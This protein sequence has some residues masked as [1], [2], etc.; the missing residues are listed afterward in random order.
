LIRA[1]RKLAFLVDQRQHVHRST[2]EQVE[3]TLDMIVV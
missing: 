3:H 2:G 1:L